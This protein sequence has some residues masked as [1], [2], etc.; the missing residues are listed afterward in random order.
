[1]SE[2]VFLNGQ[3]LD[4][5]AAGISVRDAGFLYGAGLFETMRCYSG[6][7][8]SLGDHLDRL[9]SSAQTLGIRNTYSRDEIR[10]AI[11][12]TIHANSLKDARVR[13]TLTSGQTN[14]EPS[15]LLI[16]ATP[17]EG[18]PEEYYRKGI[19]TVLCNMRQNTEEIIC[20]HKTLSYFTRM[21]AL[22]QAKAKG[23]SEAIWFTTDGRL[24]EGSI[25]NIFL[26][27]G[28]ALAT[29]PL[30]T[31]V[32]PGVARKAV[33]EIAGREMIQFVERDLFINSLLESEEVFLTNVIMGVMPV[34]AI[35]A[36]TVGDGKVGPVVTRLMKCYES[37]VQE[38]CT[39][40]LK[41]GGTA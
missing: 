41:G 31:P 4:A 14:A 27:K 33:L 39:A 34:V 5:S 18:Y 32:L 23:A 20:G 35:E 13:L 25:S 21:V 2:K 36:H 37:L 17:Y 16:M 29:P 28:G 12:A 11:Y 10:A 8:F 6:A 26:V 22:N 24:A 15:T 7:I 9:F 1:M 3:I 40:E 38:R 30:N 19:R